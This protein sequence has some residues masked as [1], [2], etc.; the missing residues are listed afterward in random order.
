MSVS[1]R[2][3]LAFLAEIGISLFKPSRLAPALFFSYGWMTATVVS[4]IANVALFFIAA[5]A[6]PAGVKGIFDSKADWVALALAVL[7]A[8]ALWRLKWGVIT[9][10]G[11]LALA[12]LLLRWLG[13]A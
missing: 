3:D 4:A 6:Y 5:V 12:G 9:V 7:A 10:I 11:A 2:P 8:L 1:V 13:L